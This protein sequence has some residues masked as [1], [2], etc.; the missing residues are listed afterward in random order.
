[1]IGF[2]K[3][4]FV[5]KKGGGLTETFLIERW[6]GAKGEGLKRFC[7]LRWG[8]GL[9]KKRGGDF[10]KGGSYPG[11]HYAKLSFPFFSF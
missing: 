9:A 8:G 11:A 3:Q 1:M 6:V 4:D 5:K 2:I 7:I 10:F